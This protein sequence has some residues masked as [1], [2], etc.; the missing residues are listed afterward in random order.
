MIG[1]IFVNLLDWQLSA[2]IF[3]VSGI[4]L[5]FIVTY[6]L[7]RTKYQNNGPL[8]CFN[9]CCRPKNKKKILPGKLVLNKIIFGLEEDYESEVESET[10][11]KTADKPN[12][13]EV[14]KDELPNDSFKPMFA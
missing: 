1:A 4:L 8:I 7:T 10:R 5:I 13:P 14:G 6:T 9:I 11:S 2:L 12:T 3:I